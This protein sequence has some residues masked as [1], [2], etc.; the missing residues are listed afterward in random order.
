MYRIN[1]RA[2][3]IESVQRYL[4]LVGS[5]NI[6]VAPTG[7]FDENTRLS[8]ID[9]QEKN[10]LEGSG[11]VD[12]ITFDLLFS[13]FEL[14][15]ETNRI[16]EG[17]DSFIVFPLRPGQLAEP[18]IHINR[19]L[20]RLLNHYRKTHNVRESNFYSKS[21]SEAVRLIRAIYLLK[22][23][24]LIDEELYGRMVADHNSINYAGN[25]LT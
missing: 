16:K 17:Y 24:D 25:N 18:M 5:P 11:V 10:E 23:T 19:M 9:F 1:D 21:T 14:I 2:S 12:R 4:R 13:A 6:F 7:V 8:V 15:N 20:A 22:D 3:A